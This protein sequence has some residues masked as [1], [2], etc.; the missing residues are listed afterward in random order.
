MTSE[1]REELKKIYAFNW[2]Q[3]RLRHGILGD[4]KSDWEKASALVDAEHPEHI[5]RLES[6]LPG[7]Y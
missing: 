3:I 6:L 1:Q 4:D 7:G 2:Y 5:N